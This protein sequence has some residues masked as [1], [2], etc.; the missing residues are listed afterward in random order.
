MIGLELPLGIMLA[1]S[2][3]ADVA[4]TRI[5]L[6]Q[7]HTCREGN[8]IM[9]PFAGSTIRLTAAQAAANSA[10]WFG[11]MKFKEQ[12]RKHWWLPVAVAIGAHTAASIHNA[13]LA[14]RAA[15]IEDLRRRVEQ[16]EKARR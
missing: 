7:C 13:R 8:P 12:H 3:S 4:T 9:R 11:A 15:T 1:L 10:L 5:A 6:T 16:L 2:T 14:S